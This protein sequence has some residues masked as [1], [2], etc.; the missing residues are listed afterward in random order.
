MVKY[1]DCRVVFEEIPECVSLAVGITNCPFTCPG[2]H[3]SYLRGDT[4]K[5]LDN[6]EIEQL[7]EKNKGIN[8]FLFMGD[9]LDLEGI[10]ELAHFVKS[11]YPE[12]KVGI[13]SGYDDILPE[14][15]EVFDYIKIG[16]YIESAGP[17]NKETT[18]QRL[19]RNSDVGLIDITSRF[20]RRK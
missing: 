6:S 1:E 11:K 14:Y 19:Y 15:M 4:G 12:I 10:C 3:S 18:N 5:I 9:G 8:C 7:I 13:Y 2:C 17:L 20:W 16:K